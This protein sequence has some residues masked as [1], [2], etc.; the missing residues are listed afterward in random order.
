MI[1]RLIVES[2]GKPLVAVLLVL[3][4]SVMGV[5]TFRELPRVCQWSVESL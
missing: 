2:F 4:C 3:A 1:Q 5:V